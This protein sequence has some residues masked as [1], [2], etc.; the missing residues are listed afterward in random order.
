M[1][2]PRARSAEVGGWPRWCFLPPAGADSAALD[3]GRDLTAY[4]TA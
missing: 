4:E 2:R 3:L 1:D